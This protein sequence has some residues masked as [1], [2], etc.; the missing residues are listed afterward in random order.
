MTGV[1][2]R[3]KFAA[4]NVGHS[5]ALPVLNSGFLSTPAYYTALPATTG[6]FAQRGFP[7]SPGVNALVKGAISAQCTHAS[8]CAGSYKRSTTPFPKR[9]T[10]YALW[11]AWLA[12]LITFQHVHVCA[13]SR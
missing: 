7:V 1:F 4:R 11:A 13:Y 2:F 5:K 3:L 12:P 10:D 9:P 8:E 6:V